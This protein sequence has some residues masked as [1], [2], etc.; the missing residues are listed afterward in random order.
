[1][2]PTWRPQRS[3]P[4]PSGLRS[5]RAS[6]RA[7]SSRRPPRVSAGLPGSLSPFGPAGS[8]WLVAEDPPRVPGHAI[9]AAERLPPPRPRTAPARRSANLPPMTPASAAQPSVA[10][11]P[12]STEMEP[13]STPSVVRTRAS[14][15]NP[16]RISPISGSLDALPAARQPAPSGGRMRLLSVSKGQA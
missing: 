2:P 11:M 9:S 4:L 15:R 1:M 16:S 14:G 6:C 5:G 7:L 8:M 3:Q 13:R 12:A 10:S